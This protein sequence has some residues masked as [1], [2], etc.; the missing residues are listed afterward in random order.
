MDLT[1]YVANS[2]AAPD[3]TALW[4][5]LKSFL[6]S[7]GFD[8]SI[9]CLMSDHPSI[10]EKAKHGLIDGYPDDWMKHYIANNY[11]ADDGIRRQSQVQRQNI[12]TWEGAEKLTPYNKKERSILNQAGDAGLKDGVVVSLC[13]V[14]HEHVCMGFASSAGGIEFT[15]TMLS[16]LK[17]ASIQFYDMHQTLHRKRT[18][19]EPKPVKLSERETEVL[20][21]AAIGKSSGDIATILGIS[22]RTVNYFMQRCFYKLDATSKTLAVVKA[23][24]LGLIAL[25]SNLFVHTQKEHY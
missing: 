7:Y 19:Y 8:S 17:L 2:H 3:D 13:N 24:R 9:F 14:H 1:A 6:L 23:L 4:D 12:F 11:E 20:Q 22:D 15:P 16:I 10:G 25:D 21:W 5:N 18:P